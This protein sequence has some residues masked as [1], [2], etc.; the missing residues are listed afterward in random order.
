MNKITR[1]PEEQWKEYYGSAVIKGQEDHVIYCATAAGVRSYTKYFHENFKEHLTSGKGKTALDVGCGLGVFPSFLSDYGF[2]VTAV[3]YVPEMIEAA[4][5]RMRGKSIQFAVAD[6]YFLPFPDN[7]FDFVTCFGVFQN[8]G[9]PTDA[10]KEMFRVLKPG[11]VMAMTTL[12]RLSLH[13][14]LHKK[15]ETVPTLRYR[16]SEMKRLLTHAGFVS[17][18]EK[19]I[20]AFPSRIV[21][22]AILK[23]HVNA[24]LNAMFGAG[25]LLSH[26]FYL[27]ARKPK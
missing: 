3:D 10:L 13:Y 27:E 2:Q 9:K 4:R 15:K 8:L 5:K 6:I 14:L 12:N 21:T 26:S 24:L 7:S 23:Y 18:K 22:D 17:V 16:P 20:Y 25:L 19:G 1:T 11:G